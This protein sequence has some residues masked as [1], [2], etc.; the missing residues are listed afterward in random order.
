[1][2]G[3]GLANT[4]AGLSASRSIGVYLGSFDPPHRGHEW[5][6]TQ[7]LVQCDTVLLLVPATHFHKSIVPPRNATLP[8]RLEMLALLRATAPDR[9][10]VGVAREVLFLELD[11][12]LQRRWPK[13]DLRYAMGDETREKVLRSQQYYL[14]SHRAWT[15]AHERRLAS[16]AARLLVFNRSGAA[17]DAAGVAPHVRS[18]SSTRIRAQVAQ[19]AAAGADPHEWAACL[20]PSLPPGILA[21]IERMGLYR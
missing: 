5:I 8:Q 16:L 2:N 11:C 20:D 18:A 15:A 10:G 7:L 21:A 14:A 4:P 19:L 6:A 9:I 12:L 13:A 1:M 3:I 17:N